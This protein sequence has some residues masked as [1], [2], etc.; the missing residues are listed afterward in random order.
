MEGSQ[1]ASVHSAITST[2]FY[3]VPQSGIQF[4]LSSVSFLPFLLFTTLLVNSAPFSGGNIQL[5]EMQFRPM[6][7]AKTIHS[8]KL[9][10]FIIPF[11]VPNRSSVL[12]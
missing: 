8:C 11:K 6:W 4:L 5:A 7:A 9:I 12:A 10:E 2:L 1:A 3:S